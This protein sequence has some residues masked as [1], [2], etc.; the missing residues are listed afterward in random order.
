[1][2]DGILRRQKS[3]HK[4]IHDGRDLRRSLLHP[5]AQSWVNYEIRS[6]CIGLHPFRS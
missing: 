4:V 1:M 2:L 5:P 6:G 3:D